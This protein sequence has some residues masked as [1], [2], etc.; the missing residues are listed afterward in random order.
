MCN[1][2]SALESK[3]HE[4]WC[5]VCSVNCRVL[6]TRRSALL[7]SEN[8]YWALMDGLTFVSPS[9]PHCISKLAWTFPYLP[10]AHIPRFPLWPPVCLVFS[11]LD[12]SP[13]SVPHAAG[14]SE[15]C[16]WKC[17]L[18]PFPSF[19]RA[20]KVLPTAQHANVLAWFSGIGCTGFT[21]PFPLTSPVPDILLPPARQLTFP[22]Y[23]PHF[24]YTLCSWSTLCP[25]RPLTALLPQPVLYIF[26]S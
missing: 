14:T 8:I 5:P 20:Y 10:S 11:P 21:F 17:G 6:P 9:H 15:G 23:I 22:G 24:S 18:K 7:E 2:F 13:C 16:S 25:K 4:G 3:F 26:I 1:Q 12:S 19:S